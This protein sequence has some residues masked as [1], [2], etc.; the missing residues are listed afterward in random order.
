MNREVGQFDDSTPP[1]G[2][3]VDPC[4]E[5]AGPGELVGADEA[6]AAGWRVDVQSYVMTDG[7][8]QDRQHS[9]VILAGATCSR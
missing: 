6:V 2:S 3:T 1:P 7:G 5:A 8:R 4:F 9:V